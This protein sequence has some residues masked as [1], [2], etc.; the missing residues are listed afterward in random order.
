[1][2]VNPG[3]AGVPTQVSQ[4]LRHPAH[5]VEQPPAER[6][7]VGLQREQRLVDELEVRRVKF[8][9]AVHVGFVDV[10]ADDRRVPGSCQQRSV[11]VEPQVALKP[12]DVERR[13]GFAHTAAYLK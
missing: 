11:V 3:D 8:R 10:E 6:D 5:P 1:V 7:E 12:D 4:D 2:G 9:V 13:R